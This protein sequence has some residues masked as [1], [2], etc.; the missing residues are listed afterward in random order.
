MTTCQS[1]ELVIGYRT[2]AAPLRQ[3][4]TPVRLNETLPVA[5]LQAVVYAF[6]VSLMTAS[7]LVGC[8]RVA[9]TNGLFIMAMAAVMCCAAV[10]MVRGLK[11]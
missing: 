9:A 1:T 8:G 2:T 7:W 3:F 10:A 4:A 5:M 11:Q 6:C